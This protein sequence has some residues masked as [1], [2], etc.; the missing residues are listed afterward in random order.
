MNRIVFKPVLMDQLALWDYI[1]LDMAGTRNIKQLET[2]NIRNALLSIKCGYPN[3]LVID[4]FLKNWL[5]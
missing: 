5:I 4:Y 2:V 1:E 3:Y